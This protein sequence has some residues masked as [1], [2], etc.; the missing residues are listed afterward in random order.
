MFAQCTLQKASKDQRRVT[1]MAHSEGRCHKAQRSLWHCQGGWDNKGAVAG[2][3][4]QSTTLQLANGVLVTGAM[5]CRTAN[6]IMV[7]VWGTWADC[8]HGSMEVEG[9]IEG[10]MVF[11]GQGDR[12][13][14]DTYG[15]PGLG[16]RTV[17]VI[18]TG[19][20]QDR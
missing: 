5:D 7:M 1:A 3:K 9:V 20:R 18:W 2:V 19:V 17:M 15:L 6:G 4:L 13:G 12:D 8:M 11:A 14:F 10:G 16:L